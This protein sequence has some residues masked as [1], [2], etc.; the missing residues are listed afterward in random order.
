MGG[1]SKIRF[2]FQA[3]RELGWKPVWL[4]GWY[5]VALRSGYLRMITPNPKP[6]V[7]DFPAWAEMQGPLRTLPDR[8][9]LAAG[10]GERGVE[11]LMSE[12]DE[13]IAGKV[14]LFGGEAVPLELTFPGALGHWT[15]YERGGRGRHGFSSKIDLKL[16]WEP[17]RFGW[18][19]VLARA[20]Y[21][22]RKDLYAEC[23]WRYTESFLEANP[24]YRGPHWLSAQEVA[25]R[26]ISLAF[27]GQV[28][29]AAPASTPQRL[30]RLA[31]A[32]ANHAARIPP[33]L[34]YARA[35]NNN[36]LLSEA[37]GLLT[38]GL[39][40]PDHPQA[41]RWQEVG[42]QWLNAG[43]QSQIAADGAYIQHSTN[44]HRLMLQL[45]LWVHACTRGESAI[46]WAENRQR[47]ALATRWLMALLDESNG[48][49]PNLGPNDGAYILP[50]TTCPFAD[51]RPVLLAAAAAFLEERP[52]PPGAWDEMGLWLNGE[53]SHLQPQTT[54][55]F[56]RPSSATPHVLHLKSHKSWAYLRIARFDS[57]P[58]HADQLHLDLWWRGLNIAQDAGTYRYTAPPPWEN[59]LTS[60]LVHNT[61]SINGQEQMRRAGRFLYLD[62]A[63]AE[64]LAYEQDSG[65]TWERM[66]AR[67]DG[68]RRLGLVHQRVL[69]AHRAG[70]WVIEDRVESLA[71]SRGLLP[72]LSQGR[73]QKSLA[74]A[75]PI[76]CLHWLL[77][78]WEWHLQAG[79]EG[80]LLY[81]RSPSGPVGL[82]IDLPEG[83]HTRRHTLARAGALLAGNGK[84]EAT[85]GWIAPTYGNKIPALSLAVEVEANPPVRLISEFVLP[86]EG[87]VP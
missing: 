50:L 83:A 6:V 2:A 16:I 38:A 62:W 59:A 25:L 37:V 29:A 51:Y 68:Y 77:P 85:R 53:M 1:F 69:T 15:D 55:F 71:S 19:T 52:F 86:V 42:G 67:H 84:V 32:L 75:A 4:Y 80:L 70:R 64:L 36:H 56:L 49:V 30:G 27:C 22:S 21:L 17:A 58:G 40:L 66:T 26:L 23:F 20:Y 54:S 35:Q 39:A 60:T 18:A 65:E 79:N 78:D 9:A 72:V 41:R 61:L 3:L 87:R 82:R 14:R 10:L 46:L 33:T 44:Y 81:L 48:Q 34:A 11:R 43:L 74:Q 24:P 57:R 5:Q 8:Q 47:L 45:A 76:I 7:G 73:G 63:Q 28:L 12:A 31:M 13:I